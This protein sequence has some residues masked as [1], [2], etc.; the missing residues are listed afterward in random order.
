MRETPNSLRA[1][2]ILG[3]ALLALGS[4]TEIV[5]AGT[6]IVLAL[7]GLNVIL[8][9]ALVVVGA[10]AP[11]LIDEA[12]VALYVAVW[13]NYVWFVLLDL[14]ALAGGAATTGLPIQ[15]LVGLGIAV[16]LTVNVR[17]LSSASGTG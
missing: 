4:I 12:P 15:V 7:N 11:K 8:A 3:G 2:F 1:Y 16:Y 14:L 13:A 5:Q 17:R 10:M 6:P 9:V